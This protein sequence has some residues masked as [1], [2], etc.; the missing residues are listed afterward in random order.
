MTHGIPLFVSEPTFATW[1][2]PVSMACLLV[3]L[4]LLPA[5]FGGTSA[6]H[7]QAVPAVDGSAIPITSTGGD[8]YYMQP[9]WAPEGGMLAFSG[10]H[11]RGI[12]VL[13]LEND[14]LSQIS[15]DPGVGFGFT[16]SRDG[17]TIL[18]RAARFDGLRRLNG[19]KIINATSGEESV[20]LP[21]QTDNVGIP[22]WVDNNNRVAVYDTGQL[23][24]LDVP[25]KAPKGETT[26]EAFMITDGD[27][28][29]RSDS[30]QQD[31]L[32]V[33]AE[34]EGSILNLTYS[35]DLKKVA[36]EVLGGD[37]F[38]MDTDGRNRVS[39]GNGNRP[40]WSPDGQWVAYQQTEDD[41][42][43]FTASELF[44]SSVD[45]QQIVQLTSTPDALEMNPSWSA[46][47]RHIAF[48]DRGAIYLLPIEYE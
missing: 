41:G 1:R 12:W 43:E 19:V 21:F 26:A 25:G 23:A 24:I 8:E 48:D 28:I 11:Y 14:R 31:D 37:L 13:N 20:V 45:G 4:L 18:A 10:L 40:T 5:I 34:E 9:R 2:W 38:V 44:A 35:P 15:N 16:W 36:F 6:I 30:G 39:L 33:I 7:A 46:D 42:H 29:L 32:L 27:R 17:S 22:T 3:G 47:N